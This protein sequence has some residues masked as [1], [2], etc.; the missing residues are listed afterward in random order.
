MTPTHCRWGILGAAFIARKN[1]QSIRD[2]K[3]AQLIAVASRDIERAQAFI[4]ECQA[5]AP[6][7]TLPEAMGSYDELLARQ[8]IDA[9]YIPLPTALRKEWVLKAARAGK[10]VLVEKPVGC[11]AADVAEIIA[12]CEQ[13]GVQFMD[14]VMFMHGQRLQQLRQVMDEDVGAP[15]HIA[16]QF[17]FK[18]DAQFQQENIRA[19][20]ALEPLGCLGDLGWYCLRFSLWAMKEEAPI[21]VTGR[22]HA[23]TQ[24]LAGGSPVPLAFSGTLTF[25]DA[26]SA[27]F[28]CCFTAA[29]AQWAIVSGE[30]AVLQVDDFVLPFS[31][32]EAKYRLTKSNFIVDGCRADM[33]S[34][35][36]Q[37]TSSEPSNNAPSSQEC[38]LF[39][40]FSNWVLSGKLDPQ[41]PKLSLLT[42]RVLDACLQS[43]HQGSKPIQVP[44]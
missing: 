28:Y 19:Q 6:H 34:G 7:D 36:D 4:T 37:R 24:A 42:Q 1:W 25:A 22:I 43:A 30:N 2:A 44:Q 21:E 26:A 29:H 23:Q 20:S 38:R 10:H 3:N 14:G 5:S 16:T 8:D 33:H 11:D 17:S 41:W 35:Q 12:T 9:V 27:S 32:H 18:A 15:R 39:E 31:G 13:H 40:T